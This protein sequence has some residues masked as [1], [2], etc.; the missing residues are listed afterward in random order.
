MILAVPKVK[1]EK[2][3]VLQIGSTSIIPLKSASSFSL[4]DDSDKD[5]AE[6]SDDDMVVEE[7]ESSTL[8]KIKESLNETKIETPTPTPE[9][10]KKNDSEVSLRNF[11]SR[12]NM[13]SFKN[14]DTAICFSCLF[15][16]S[17]PAFLDV[18]GPLFRSSYTY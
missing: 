14:L 7:E 10:T 12:M 6:A 9:E 2:K 13:Y 4:D 16:F 5:E 17:C 18:S 3:K 8:K 1:K 15:Y 11:Y